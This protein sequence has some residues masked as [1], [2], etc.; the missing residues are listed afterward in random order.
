MK[1]DI[2]II[3]HRGYSSLYPDNSLESFEQ[4][5]KA[6]AHIIETDIHEAKDGA[7]IC[8][9]DPAKGA[10][11]SFA[12]ALAFAKDK[13]TLLLDLKVDRP[14][15]NAK[16][17]QALKD[18]GMEDQVIV[19]V[20]SLEQ[21]RQI[22]ALLPKAQ[23]L[24]FLKNP[25][26]FPEF[27]KIGGTIARLWESDINEK[28]LA[29]AKSG[30]NPVFVMTGSRLGDVGETTPERLQKIMSLGVQGVLVNDPK[31]ALQVKNEKPKAPSPPGISK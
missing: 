8:S 21:A 10:A 28:N 27:F 29:L 12:D 19:G 31:Q 2:K 6:G 20:R 3:A 22:K 7:L 18:H 14:E 23:M 25:S 16:V 1:N 9:H 24:G 13:I 30:G 17:V 5:V 4:A 26:D 11:L 15:F